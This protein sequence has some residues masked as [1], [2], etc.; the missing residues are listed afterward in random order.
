M[1]Q[2]ISNIDLGVAE[3]DSQSFFCTKKEGNTDLDSNFIRN[4]SIRCLS[5]GIPGGENIHVVQEMNVF[6]EFPT[7]IDNDIRVNLFGEWRFGAGIGYRNVVLLT[8]GTGLGSGIIKEGK[9]IYG[10]TSSTGEIG[11]MNMYRE[12]RPCRCG[13]S[14]CLGRYV[15]AV[16]MVNTLIER[17][18]EG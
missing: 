18:N 13:S 12:G 9:V 6:F 14:G 10:K 8:L 5:M 2:Y 16:G 17:L 1:F 4:D 11:H 15:S 3:S 7:F